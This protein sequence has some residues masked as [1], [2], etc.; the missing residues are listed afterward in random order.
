MDFIDFPEERKLAIKEYSF[1]EFKE[2]LNFMPAG[3]LSNAIKV[4]PKM[5]GFR[6]GKDTEI[7]LKVFFGRIDRWDEKDWG[8]FSKIWLLWTASQERLKNLLNSQDIKG[9]VEKMIESQSERL[10]IINNLVNAEL[11]QDVIRYWLKFGPFNIDMDTLWLVTLAPTPMIKKLQGRF[12]TLERSFELQDDL[13]KKQIQIVQENLSI[14]SND[15]DEFKQ[16]VSLL[17]GEIARITSRTQENAY[18]LS[19]LN[20]DVGKLSKLESISSDSYNRLV[21]RVTSI[22]QKSMEL[23]QH[24]DA[25]TTNHS[26][27]EDSF[28][29]LNLN[30]LISNTMWDK[31]TVQIAASAEVVDQLVVRSIEFKSTPTQLSSSEEA[32][33][34]LKNNLNSIGIKLAD[35]KSISFEVLSAVLSNQ[36][37][38]FSGSM[39]MFVAEYCAAS[40]CGHIVKVIN[41]PFGKTE[42]FFS[43]EQLDEWINEAKSCGYPIAII[44]EGINRS[45]FEVYGANLKK[46]IA[47]RIVDLKNEEIPIIFMATLVT[48]PSVLTLSRELL[49]IGPIFNTDCIGWGYKHVTPYING[50]IDSNLLIRKK[51]EMNDYLE[52][53]DLLPRGIVERGSILWRKTIAA[54]YKMMIQLDSSFDFSS[55]N[56]GWL[57]PTTSIYFTDHM[58]QLFDEIELDERCKAL[59]KHMALEV[60]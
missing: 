26:R 42:E 20:K 8:L 52:I 41:V 44:L 33:T 13:L 4:L 18:V 28:K 16:E 53:E 22:N 15:F 2:F 31:K 56:F 29:E 24:I 3:V 36:L 59:I 14:L 57:I 43:K 10:R 1:D 45:A 6:A 32:L 27:L 54:T 46:F 5:K 58:E 30:E 9:T 25:L 19:T 55:V 37:V 7:R 35:A 49:D 21:E 34:H 23:E 11:T 40:L 39:G 48:G 12:D 47:E 51:I 60:Q 17:R 50:V 38:M